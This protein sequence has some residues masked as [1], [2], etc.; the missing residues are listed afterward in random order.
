MESNRLLSIEKPDV[1]FLF[2]LLLFDVILIIKCQR[3]G[4]I[5]IF[6]KRKFKDLTVFR[7]IF[8]FKVN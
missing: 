3:S 1:E 2:G 6:P 8:L 5:P 7:I 4:L